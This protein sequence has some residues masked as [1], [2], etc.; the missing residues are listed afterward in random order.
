MYYNG[1]LFLCIVLGSFFGY[2]AFN[3]EP[4]PAG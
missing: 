2:F 4:I 1:Y 3:W